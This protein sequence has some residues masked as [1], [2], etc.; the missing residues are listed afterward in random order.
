[1][2]G[3]IPS[4]QKVRLMPKDM[5]LLADGL[6]SPLLKTAGIVFPYT[7]T[8][9]VGHAGHYGQ[10][11]V[12]HGQYQQQYFIS[13]PNPTISLTATFTSQSRAELEY[14]VA[15]LT[16]LKSCTKADFGEQRRD[17]AG[18]PPPVLLFS[19]YG[20]SHFKNVPVVVKTL[21]YTLPEDVDY[22]SSSLTIAAGSP[23]SSSVDITLEQHDATAGMTGVEYMPTET[24]T[25]GVPAQ[26]NTA[27]MPTQLI[28][29]IELGV[30]Y[31]P[32]KVRKE[33]NIQDYRSGKLLND[34]GFV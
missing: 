19:A 14:T 12:T 20:I 8:I 18:T 32:T 2:S 17:T 9:M 34:K 1:M 33:F 28:V 24:N 26:V 4:D 16:F 21:N 29:S 10:Y 23:G 30:Q 3:G 15:C 7:P 31:P 13:S 22:V 5:S 6:V 27:S 11:E 25:A